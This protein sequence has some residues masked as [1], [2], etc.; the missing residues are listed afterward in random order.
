MPAKDYELHY[1]GSAAEELKIYLLS[2]EL[3]WP[4]R[5]QPPSGKPEYPPMS[6]GN[7]L[8]FRKKLQGRRESG[9]LKSA[10]KTIYLRLEERFD[11]LIQAWRTAWDKK[12][13]KEFKSRFNQW[14]IILDEM[15][16]DPGNRAGYYKSEVRVRVL[17]ELLAQN[18]RGRKPAELGLLSTLDQ[19]LQVMTKDAQFLWEDEMMGVFGRETYWFLYRMTK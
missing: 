19:K 4:I 1:L 3:Y 6:P 2:N 16:N 8:L 17:L 5:L 12:V 7:L 18:Y 15:N 13:A 9:S 14:K 11:D 10:E